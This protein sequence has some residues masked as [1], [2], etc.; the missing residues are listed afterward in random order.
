MNFR[1]VVFALAGAFAATCLLPAAELAAE[2]PVGKYRAWR[3]GTPLAE[4]AKL[5]GIASTETKV[6]SRRPQ[7]IEELDLRT[8]QSFASKPDSVREI[9]F[10]FYN[11]GLFEM[12]IMYDRDQTGGLTDADM[13]EA[14]AAVYGPGSAPATKEMAFN[15]GYNNTVRVIAQWTDAQSM[16]SL[17]GFPYA[18]GF[19]V[20]VSSKA[21][22]A[23]A[24]QAILE[25]AR[26]DRV[27]APQRELELR[28]KQAA[29][30]AAKDEQSRLVNKPGFRP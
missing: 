15:S 23:L 9:L 12:M 20:V 27:E 3:L 26:L 4:V 8:S 14:L 24:K 1:P 29:D 5:A 18:A 28:A 2:S 30:M 11:G 17:V 16:L 13:T 6:I 7:R 21:N 10:R 22:E 19:G 25:S